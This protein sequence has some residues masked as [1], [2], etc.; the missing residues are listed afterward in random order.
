[1]Y[2]ILKLGNSIVFEREGIM[3]EKLR[4]AGYGRVSTHG[5]AEKGTQELQTEAI[6]KECEK[7]DYELVHFYSDEGISGKDMKN[8]P[9]I[10]SLMKDAKAGKFDVVIFT[11][12]D[13]VGRSLRDILNF[14]HLINEDLGLDLYCIAQPFLSTSGQFGKMMLAVLGV[15]A[16][17]E[18]DLI[19]ERTTEGRM[20]S[21]NKLEGIIGGLPL[22]YVLNKEK[23]AIEIEE[24]GAKI[25]HKIVSYYLDENHSMKDVAILLESEGM[26]VASELRPKKEKNP[27]DNSKKK[28]K[29]PV[30]WTGAS[31]SVILKNESYKG[32]KILN[33]YVHESHNGP[34]GQYYSK[35]KELKPEA[36]WVT[37]KFPP[38]I[39]ED[40]WNMIQ[41][42]TAHQKRKPKKRHK[43][44]EDH[45]LA[46]SL[47]FCGECGGRIRKRA[48][49]RAAGKFYLRY[50][51]YWRRAS[52]KGLK[53]AGREKCILKPMDEDVIDDAV[54][55]EIVN[56]LTNP[57]RFAKQ[58]LQ[59]L[60][61]EDVN[62]QL[63]NLR[64]KEKEKE[65][66]VKNSFQTIKR[67]TN[68][69]LLADFHKDIDK[70][71]SDLRDIQNKL[72]RIEADH[73][74]AVGKV[75]RLKQFEKM[76]KQPKG[77]K[78]I[79]AI[80]QTQAEFKQFLY[81]LPFQEKK[82]IVESV[83]APENGGKA[84]VRYPR[85]DDILDH[86]EMAKIPKEERNKPLT[87]QEPMVEISFHLDINRIEALISGLNRRELLD[88][89]DCQQVAGGIEDNILTHPVLGMAPFGFH[90]RGHQT[91][92]GGF[93]GICEETLVFRR[94]ANNFKFIFRKIEPFLNNLFK[95]V[96]VH[97]FLLQEF[98]AGVAHGIFRQPGPDD[99]RKYPHGHMRRKSSLTQ[100]TKGF[101]SLS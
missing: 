26:P 27:K 44:L 75:D 11:K 69:K 99:H 60:D 78:K 62:E 8:R 43:G 65:L 87:E 14:W 72:R 67:I 53:E 61:V 49:K 95:P 31:I 70:E 96:L 68:K 29:R 25:Y 63:K 98:P 97:F 94:F 84:I 33:Q 85:A 56:V 4:A 37:I 83:I 59:D 12:L 74:T 20:S 52:Q 21:W 79:N 82:R 9:G 45:F 54:F 48:D 39:S 16:E 24:K 40:R 10:Q 88:Q 93:D 38:L 91:V 73:A 42:K 58:W 57:G 77:K 92:S 50:S 66:A 3:T 7:L 76:M 101:V 46:D 2:T 80:F 51:C 32:E 34:S 28:P 19:R 13:R 18:R 22:G 15:F 55:D 41:A 17:L 81:D 35:G 90:H 89:T 30:K 47:L 1:M 6:E 5:Q 86:S 23:N 100:G 64:A 36:E 71:Q